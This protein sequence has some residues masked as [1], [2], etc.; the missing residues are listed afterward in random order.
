MTLV[1]PFHK[2][3]LFQPELA[4]AGPRVK[5]AGVVAFHAQPDAMPARLPELRYLELR[6]TA[7]GDQGVSSIDTLRKLRNLELADTKVSELGLKF[8]GRVRSLRSL[9]L[10]GTRVTDNGLTSLYGL[11]DLRSIYL[12]STAVTPKEIMIRGHTVSN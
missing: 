9:D 4:V 12:E 2:P 6:L 3:L 7:V 11:A 5:L 1:S 10:C 8:I